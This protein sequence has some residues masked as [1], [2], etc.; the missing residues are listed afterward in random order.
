[1]RPYPKTTLVW[2]NLVLKM[3]KNAKIELAPKLSYN[4]P[5]K[6]IVIKILLNY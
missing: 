1:M 4:V 6:V 3:Q 2:K 5:P